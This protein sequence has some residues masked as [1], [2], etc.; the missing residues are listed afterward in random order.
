[1]YVLKMK[2]FII[3]VLSFEVVHGKIPLFT[4]DEISNFHFILYV[5]TKQFGRRI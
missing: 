1:M 2:S 4:F 3:Y 5:N